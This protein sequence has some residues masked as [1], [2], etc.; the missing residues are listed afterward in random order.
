MSSHTTHFDDC[1]C[2]SESFRAEILELRERNR[3]LE[4]QNRILRLALTH[5]SLH[6]LTGPT[7]ILIATKALK[8]A[9]EV[10]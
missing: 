1:G 5:I 3:V 2:K 6:E 10:K 9:E 4:E 8:A 7:D